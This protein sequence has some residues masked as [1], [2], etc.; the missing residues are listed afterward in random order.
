MESKDS[1]WKDSIA[2]VVLQVLTGLLPTKCTN[3]THFQVFDTRIVPPK[4][5]PLAPEL[6]QRKKP[7]EKPEK[8]VAIGNHKSRMLKVPLK[9]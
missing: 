4:I 3:C 6:K 8:S 9:N 7:A 2:S 5:L 1:S